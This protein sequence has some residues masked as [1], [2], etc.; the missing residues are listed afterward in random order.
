[1][2]IP[3]F[4]EFVPLGLE[5]KKEVDA[6]FK[7][8]EPAISE[9]TFTNLFIWRH[10]YKV[11]LSRYGGFLLL[12]SRREGKPPF[13]F[14]PWGDGDA[15]P[16]I[17]QCVEY[18]G[19]QNESACIERAPG[20]Y[21]ERHVRPSPDLAMFADPDNEDY[22]YDSQDLIE[23]KGR[24]YD[25]KRNAISK[26]QR[27][28]RYEYRRIDDNLIKLC[29]E[30]Q[31]FWCA[32]RKCELYARLLEER[33]AIIEAFSNC[34][35]LGIRGGAILMDGKVEA[36]SLGEKLNSNTFV[37]HIEKANQTIPGLYAMINQQF[38]AHEAPA[39]AYVNREQDLGDEGLRMAKE[40]YQPAFKVQKF[41]VCGRLEKKE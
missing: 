30:L 12:L 41:K 2:P 34:G 1:M 28:S 22:V 40:S 10:Y 36:F 29:L 11:S 9:F 33:R 5:H 6:A 3:V 26:F 27:S 31:D 35:M 21:V 18:I 37:V 7:Q 8:T 25:G 14:P 17:R 24:K 13:F 32:E 39:F 15:R 38:A 23:L 4:P 20:G 19:R 16:V